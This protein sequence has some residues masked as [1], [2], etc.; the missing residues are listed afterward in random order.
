MAKEISIKD[1]MVTSVITASA[2]DSVC[3]A[4]LKMKAHKIGVVVIVDNKQRI[5]G[6]ISERDI[7]NKVVCLGLDS[8]SVLVE[9]IMTKKVI[10]GTPQMT[11]VQTAQLFTK[12]GIKKLPLI[13]KG[14]LVGIITQTDLLKVLSFKWAL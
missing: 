13:E 12:H 9:Q 6:V 2:K 7:I 5:E 8:R 11:D 4:A 14:K 1:I 3:D 10:T